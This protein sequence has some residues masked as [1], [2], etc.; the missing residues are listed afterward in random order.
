MTA[1]TS[2]YW[3]KRPEPLRRP[4]ASGRPCP[5]WLS[6]ILLCLTLQLPFSAEAA[7]NGMEFRYHE[8]VPL[9]LLYIV[10]ASVEMQPS[11]R[12]QE[13]VES[14][15]SVPFQAEFV[16]TH[17]RWYWLDETIVTRSMNFRLAYH[18]LTRQYRLSIGSIHRSFA[19]F[20]EALRAM[21]TL[22]N[23]MVLDRNRLSDGVALPLP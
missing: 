18:A 12:L 4:A 14:G 5:A 6:L 19:S 10:N 2:H 9:D 15:L 21:L 13:M 16:L 11:P 3:K 1:S 17:A 23:W 8:V 20:D 22:R 7:G